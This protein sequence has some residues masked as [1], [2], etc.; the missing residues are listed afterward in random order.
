MFLPVRLTVLAPA[1]LVPEK[2]YVVRVPI[3]GVID[4]FFITPNQKVQPGQSLF[5]LD[6]TSLLSRLQIAQQELNV[7]STEHKQTAIQSL[8]DLK[9]RSLLISQEGK[10]SEK[11]L[12]ADY[13]KTLVEKAQISSKREG[14]AIFDDPSSWIGKPVAAGEKIMLIATETD[15]EIE[16]WLALNEIIPLKNGS[17]VSLFLNSAPLH[18]ITGNI[19][20]LGHEPI[21]RPDGSFAYRLRASIQGQ[22]ASAR[23]GFRGTAKISGDF[24]P[25]SYWILRKPFATARQF[26]GL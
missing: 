2:P 4:E 3:D 10:V 24:V 5:R 19:R 11:K 6:L 25:L 9:S 14:I 7:A 15:M 12:E 23:I 22:P 20:Y 26:F 1:E 8:T 18:P 16:A 13:L 21:Q 17:T